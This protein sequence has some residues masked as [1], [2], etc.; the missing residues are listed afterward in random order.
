MLFN[1]ART[2]VLASIAAAKGVPA[3]AS[4]HDPTGITIL[5]GCFLSLWAVAAYMGTRTR[6]STAASPVAGDD[7][8]S[9]SK[10]VVPKISV[11]ASPPW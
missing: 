1:V 6:Q 7:E 2:F 5:L 3:I 10:E 11:S 4:W 9:V 8:V